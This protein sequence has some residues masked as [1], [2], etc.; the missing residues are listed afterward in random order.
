MKQSQIDFQREALS[1]ESRRDELF[2]RWNSTLSSWVSLDS[3]PGLDHVGREILNLT[4]AR[5]MDDARN[6]FLSRVDSTSRIDVILHNADSVAMLICE[7]GRQLDPVVVAST[8]N[9]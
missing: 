7:M 4:K 9:N 2:A 3:V 6:A 8:S 1:L 5:T